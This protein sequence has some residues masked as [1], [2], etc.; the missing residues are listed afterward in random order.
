MHGRTKPNKERK[1]RP[2]PDELLRTVEDGLS[3]LR[4]GEIRKMF[5]YPCSFIGRQMFVSLHQENMILRLSESDGQKFLKLDGAAPFEPMPGRVMREYVV[6]PESILSP[7]EEL[8]AWLKKTFAYAECLPPKAPR[9]RRAKEKKGQS[10][11]D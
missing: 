4:G 10:G 3:F 9:K 7:E 1:E 8:E 2:A 5:G 6:V 11:T